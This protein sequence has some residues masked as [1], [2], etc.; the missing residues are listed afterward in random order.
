MRK[1]FFILTILLPLY[2][3]GQK[4]VY[5]ITDYGA[6]GD[7][8]TLNTKAIQEAVDK[9]ADKGGGTVI[10]PAGTFV[11]G[12]IILKSN[13][14]LHLNNGAVL[15]GSPDKDDYKVIVP[16]FESRTNDL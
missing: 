12:C 8:R 5:N 9:C 3:A 10:V 1:L 16:K 11:T 4:T 15:L 7:N 2:A 6:K 14:N 13:V